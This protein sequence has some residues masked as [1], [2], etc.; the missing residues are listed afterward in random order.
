MQTPE[1]VVLR[2]KGGPAKTLLTS[3]YLSLTPTNLADGYVARLVFSLDYAHLQEITD[4][5]PRVLRD[6]VEAG[7]RDTPVAEHVG[8]VEVFFAEAA[9][10]SVDVRICVDVDGAA[11]EF[12]RIV[13]RILSRLCVDACIE[14]GWSIPFPQLTVHAGTPVLR[15]VGDAEPPTEP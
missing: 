4:E 2:L 1:Q 5:I 8:E 13:P 12:Y 10:S 15:P 7:L 11:G 14:N 6:F 9:A 3:D